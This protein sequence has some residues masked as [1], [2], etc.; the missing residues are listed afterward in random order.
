MLPCTL[1]AA[2]KTRKLPMVIGEQERAMTESDFPHL[3]SPLQ[4]GPKTL[5]NRVLV[6][7][8][9][10]RIAENGAPGDQ[11]VA[12]HRTKA[13]GG[14]AM[15]ITGATPVH[16]SSALGSPY[17]L[18][19]TDDSII[20]GYQRLADAVHEEGGCMLAQLAHYS[21][22]IHGGEPGQPLW[23]ASAVPSEL[24]RETPHAMT[25]GEIDE[26]VRAFGAAAG[27]VRQGGLDGIEILGAFGLLIANFLSP[28]ANKRSDRYGGSLENRMRFPIEVIEAVREAAGPDL[29][30]GMRIPGDEFVDDGLDQE[31]MK[32]VAQILEATAKLD[33]LNVIA[34]TNLDRV[35]RATHW[36]PTPAP[37][38]LFVPLAAGIK[39]VVDLPVF[40]VGRIVDPHHA[41]R[42][43]ADGHADMVGVTRAHIADPDIV[44]KISSGR[45]DDVRPC[46]GANVCI[47]RAL[48]GGPIRCIHNPEAAR[49]HDWGAAEPAAVAKRVAVIGGG[50][51]GLE[52]ARVAAERGHRV[53]LYERDTVLGGQFMLR[54]SIRTWAEFQGV[55][56]WRRDQLEKLQVRV[57]L[58]HTINND[59][60]AGLGADSIVLATGAEPL[61]VEV[62]GAAGSDVEVLSPHDAV[63]EGRPEAR[64]AVVWD[65]AGGVIGLGAAEALIEGGCRVHVVTP[66]FAVA[67]DIDL[68]LRVPLYHRLMEA[69]T[70]FLPNSEVASLDGNDVVLQNVYSGEESRIEG[71]DLLIAWHGNRAVD[72]LRQ[73]I[74]D[75][76]MELHVVGDSLAPRLAD[77]AI[78]EGALAA[79]RI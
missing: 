70:V 25:I 27:R 57:E 62:P 67:E 35:H 7:A 65:H 50:P 72:G 2:V 59:D 44:A 73:A 13:R 28:H 64:V 10:P 71:V 68:V 75:A 45:A 58:G 21:A 53:T 43:V 54:A 8:H 61:T 77:V 52:A 60:I 20:P 24:V 66:A 69:G 32:E 19:N 36:P 29:I 49:E 30:V 37:H 9:V 76:G 79:R 6:T 16:R 46:V 78:A 47:A 33:Y 22:G 3:L 56:D 40:T 14:V 63:R 26:M 4:V 41:E 18:E 42:I 48:A 11:Y 1:P 55:I 17:A 12:Y 74:E 38:G 51:A 39:A 31:A 5:R 34:G 23:A 15:Q